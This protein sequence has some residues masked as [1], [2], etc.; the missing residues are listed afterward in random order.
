MLSSFLLR[1]A[2][3]PGWILK[4]GF[5]SDFALGLKTRSVRQAGA[6]PTLHR[7]EASVLRRN[8]GGPP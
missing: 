8:R 1:R 6:G 2:A 7:A 5:L 3:F 4:A